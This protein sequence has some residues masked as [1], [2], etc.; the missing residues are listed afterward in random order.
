M[1]EG[2]DIF[3]CGEDGVSG[4]QSGECGTEWGQEVT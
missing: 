1:G 3:F 2:S 4:T